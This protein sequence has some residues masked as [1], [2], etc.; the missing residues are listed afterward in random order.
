M[1]APR[2]APSAEAAPQGQIDLR[3]IELSAE[4]VTT[5]RAAAA[6]IHGLREDVQLRFDALGERNDR[7]HADNHR[8]MAERFAGLYTKVEALTAMI[9]TEKQG[10]TESE[11]D[12]ARLW[13]K[14]SVT[15]GLTL[16]A[17]LLSFSIYLLVNDA[18][19]VRRAEPPPSNIQQRIDP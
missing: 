4:A 5:A 8:Y 13:L 19:F 16:S 2:Q 18:P 11:R 7:Q 10:R 3:A 9:A 1:A 17:A 14:I 6:D 12:V 15:I